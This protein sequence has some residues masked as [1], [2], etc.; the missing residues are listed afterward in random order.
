MKKEM[1]YAEEYIER[2]IQKKCPDYRKMSKL[3][4]ALEQYELAQRMYE[5]KDNRNKH[6]ISDRNEFALQYK[7]IKDELKRRK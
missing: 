2:L 3:D 4:L 1:D 5:L 6:A 7:C